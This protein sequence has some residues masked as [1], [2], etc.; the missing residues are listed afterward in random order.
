MNEIKGTFDSR[1]PVD[2]KE[3][4]S[5]AKVAIAGL[6]GLGS[7]IALMLCRSGVGNLLLVDFDKVDTSNL[8]RQ[9]YCLRHLGMKK[10][11]ALEEIIGEINPAVKIEKLCTKVDFDN[12]KD[13]FGDYSIVCEA[14]DKPDMKAMLISTLLSS[15][16]NTTV[17]SGNGMAGYSDGNKI[18]TKKVMD[19]LYVCGD[20]VS[21]IEK[22]EILMASRVM[23]CA[24]HQANKVIQLI[25]E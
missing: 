3:K 7:N 23:I 24:G 9:A 4:L 20:G 25:L 15:C 21:D 6:G 5:S 8:N 17:V 19:K 1:L 14:F 11:D 10:T 22:G 2:I 18:S 16:P 12:A 13:I